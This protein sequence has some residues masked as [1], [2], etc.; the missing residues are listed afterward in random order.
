MEND[1]VMV[2]VLFGIPDGRVGNT[3]TRD[4]RLRPR[5]HEANKDD[6]ISAIALFDAPAASRVRPRSGPCH[7]TV[8]NRWYQRMIPS[9]MNVDTSS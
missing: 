2:L 3:C 6:E 1:S 4:V 8:R 7:T 5:F 9:N